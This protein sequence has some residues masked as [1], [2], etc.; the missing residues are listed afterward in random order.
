[1]YLTKMS[2]SL[3]FENR[4]DEQGEAGCGYHRSL[5]HGRVFAFLRAQSPIGGLIFYSD[6]GAGLLS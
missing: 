1:M 3:K 6:R 2:D 5:N 4:E